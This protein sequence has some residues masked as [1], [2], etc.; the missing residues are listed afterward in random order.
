MYAKRGRAIYAIR[1]EFLNLIQSELNYKNFWFAISY[2]F[3][4][5]G[6]EIN[7]RLDDGRIN[8]MTASER[9]CYMQTTLADQRVNA[10]SKV[11]IV[12]IVL[13]N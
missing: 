11:G 1:R 3:I 5:R 10:W 4:Y 8:Y 6:S 7:E 12:G 9:F 2:K 13:T